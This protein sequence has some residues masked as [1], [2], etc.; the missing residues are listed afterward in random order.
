[1]KLSPIVI[2][3]LDQRYHMT[4]TLLKHWTTGV[5]TE[6][7]TFPPQKYLWQALAYC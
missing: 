2:V 6:S 1:M 3:D 7:H 5:F 4:P